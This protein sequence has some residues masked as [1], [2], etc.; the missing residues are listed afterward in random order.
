MCTTVPS[1]LLP[2]LLVYCYHSTD[3]R[4]CQII[5]YSSC[6]DNLPAS[7]SLC[8][9]VNLQIDFY[10]YNASSLLILH[11]LIITILA[12]EFS[13]F[14]FCNEFSPSSSFVCI[15][16]GSASLPYRHHRL[17]PS[18]RRS[19]GVSRP[20]YQYHNGHLGHL[21]SRGRL[22][23]RQWH[24]MLPG[25]PSHLLPRCLQRI[26]WSRCRRHRQRRSCMLSL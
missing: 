2:E 9:A 7:V 16:S 22:D 10:Y 15:R 23:A 12:F 3:H 4:R 24:S 20:C 13:L 11:I 19:L 6:V 17:L 25:R 18:S 8:L 26:H 14:F 5:D 21:S 1:I